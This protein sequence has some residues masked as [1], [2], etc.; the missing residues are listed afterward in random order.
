MAKKTTP[1]KA[2]Q[3]RW[4]WDENMVFIELKSKVYRFDVLIRDGGAILVI[5]P[6]R[7]GRTTMGIMLS[8]AE[9]SDLV[10]FLQMAEACPKWTAKD[11]RNAKERA[12][13]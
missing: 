9:V 7:D 4:R 5:E 10:T 12:A 8:K 13:R 3:N 6:K 2:G 1:P 11:L